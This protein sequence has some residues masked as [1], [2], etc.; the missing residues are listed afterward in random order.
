MKERC[1]KG[2]PSSV[3]GH[4]WQNLSGSIGLKNQ[5]NGVFEVSFDFQS[6]LKPSFANDLSGLV[7]TRENSPD[8]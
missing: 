1:R 4:A 6:C 8:N 7:G 5:N 2:I 3:R